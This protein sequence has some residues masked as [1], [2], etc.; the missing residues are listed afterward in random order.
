MIEFRCGHGDM[1]APTNDIYKMDLKLEGN[2]G[3]D[4]HKFIRLVTA[5]W[6]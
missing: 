5:A 2:E 3:R 1:P 6:I 4:R